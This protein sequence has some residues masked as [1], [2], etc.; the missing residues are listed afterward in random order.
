MAGNGGGVSRGRER[1]GRA[2]NGAGG[3][4]WRRDLHKGRDP[5]GEFAYGQ[6]LPLGRE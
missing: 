1:P 6:F 2:G 4:A 5:A 3:V